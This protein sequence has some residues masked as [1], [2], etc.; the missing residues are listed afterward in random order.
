MLFFSATLTKCTV[1]LYERNDYSC[2]VSKRIQAPPPS[3][4]QKNTELR[5]QNFKHCH[6]LW[7]KHRLLNLPAPEPGDFEEFLLLHNTA[8][9]RYA[10]HLISIKHT[11]AV[12]KEIMCDSA[13]LF[14]LNIRG[15]CVSVSLQLRPSFTRQCFCSLRGYIVCICLT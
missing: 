12:L 15:S 10:Y 1:L 5:E 7:H 4:L 3:W 8:D 11:A 6:K 13:R 9:I 2:Y 14:F